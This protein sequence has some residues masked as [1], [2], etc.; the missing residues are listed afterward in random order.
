[1][2]KYMLILVLFLWA[3]H[4]ESWIRNPFNHMGVEIVTAGYIEGLVAWYPLDDNS[5]STNLTSSVDGVPDLL[6]TLPSQ[7]R[8]V[9]GKI[10]GAMRLYNNSDPRFSMFLNDAS[11]YL[12]MGSSART[13]CCWMKW[14][15][16]SMDGFGYLWS[17]PGTAGYGTHF[18]LRGQDGAQTDAENLL[19]FAYFL[20][21]NVYNVFPNKNQWYHLACSFD[22][23]STA[24]VYVN[25][26]VVAQDT[27]WTGVDTTAGTGWDACLILGDNLSDS[28][29]DRSFAGYMDDFRVYSH[30]LT[31][32]Q[33]QLIITAAGG[34]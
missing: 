26:E 5:S 13:V 18:G 32:E 1:M 16:N 22:G 14:V 6:A 34:L 33:L 7:D 24:T 15:D 19:F 3:F 23:E 17:F 8:H 28:Y 12:P 27:N 11:Q 2:K 25:G 9:E 31:P 10:G 30:A 20:D 29:G 21:L 4:S